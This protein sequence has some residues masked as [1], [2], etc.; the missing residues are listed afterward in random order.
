MRATIKGGDTKTWHKEVDMNHK[1]KRARHK[2]AGCKMC[3]P[4][5]GRSVGKDTIEF[6]KYSDYKRMKIAEERREEY[7]FDN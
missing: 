1:R 4:W 6:Q 7:Q 5:K 3:K 2:R